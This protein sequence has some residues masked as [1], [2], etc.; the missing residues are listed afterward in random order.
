MITDMMRAHAS[1]TR[2]EN[3]GSVGTGII[4]RGGRAKVAKNYLQ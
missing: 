2:R 1:S 3:I 4:D